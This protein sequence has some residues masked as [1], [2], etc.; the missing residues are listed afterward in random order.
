MDSLSI[1][2]TLKMVLYIILISA[3]GIIIFTLINRFKK[4][5]QLRLLKKT[6]EKE[7][8]RT[9]LEIQQ[10][11]L[12]NISKE[13]HDNVGQALSLVKLNMNMM[14]CDE[15]EMMQHKIDHS[16]TLITK[17]IQDL[18]DLSKGIDTEYV[19]EMGL[20]RSIEYELELI[21]KTGSFETVFSVEGSPYRLG[22]Q[23]EL[24]LF[25]MVQEA[26]HNIIEH[27]HATLVSVCINFEP[28]KC[29]LTIS[30]N[31]IGFNTSFLEDINHNS[32]GVSIRNMYNR[33]KMINADFKL[34]SI[35]ETG[36]TVTVV[37]PRQQ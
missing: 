16:K 33:A 2:F 11:T 14:T 24:I 10:Q 28:E 7:T 37:M 1:D 23:Q 21:K 26:L 5:Q 34:N 25:R 35:L 30:D 13:V 31:G 20:T 15:P 19:K 8:L 27:A 36:T 29:S 22:Q 32:F 12:K 9:Q 3:A 6:L 4:Q 18:R 17:A